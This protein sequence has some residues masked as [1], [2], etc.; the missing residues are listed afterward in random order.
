MTFRTFSKIYG[1]A[2]LRVGYGMGH[3]DIV[4][5][6]MKA[7]LPFEPN[8]L[9]QAAALG[10]LDD[11]EFLNKSL[12]LNNEGYEFFRNELMPFEDKGKL[13]FIP[14]SANFIMLDLFSESKVEMVNGILLSKGVIIRPLRPF[15]LPSCIRITMGL[16]K[17]NQAFISEFRKLI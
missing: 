11:D 1:I 9:A 6:L 16:M 17:E 8:S 4:E 15:G 10:A 2:G 14:S 12:D 3:P 7:K 5:T 13:R